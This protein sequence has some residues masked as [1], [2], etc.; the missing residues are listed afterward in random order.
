MKPLITLSTDFGTKDP[1]IAAVKGVLLS[2]LPDATIIDITHELDVFKPCNALPFL[3]DSITWFPGHSFHLVIVDPGVGSDRIPLQ[4][5]SPF[6]WIFLPDNGL[7][8]L[9]NQWFEG[10][11]FRKIPPQEDKYPNRISPTFQ[12]RDLFAKALIDQAQSPQGIPLGT[13]LSPDALVKPSRPLPPGFSRVWN[14]DH[15]GNV[16]LGHHIEEPPDSITVTG[17]PVPL[18]FVRFYQDVSVGSPG[19]LINSS[20]WL[21]IFQREGSAHHLL[22]IKKE[23]LVRITITGGRFRTF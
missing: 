5:L 10:L 23:D 12:A 1:Y 4:I 11:S 8:F 16:L 19:I 18:P 13:P 15:F 17:F 21:E 9:M 3:K 14:I 20:G 22:N 6:G 7:P 2:S